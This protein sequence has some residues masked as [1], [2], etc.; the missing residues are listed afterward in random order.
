MF[1]RAINWTGQ[2]IG[3]RYSV[4]SIL[5]KGGMGV[6][7]LAR[8]RKLDL[9]VVLKAP[10]PWMLEDAE[11]QGRFQREI[12]A[13]AAL[14]HPNVVRILD[15]GEHEGIPFAVMPHLA[16]GSLQDRFPH[17]P[18]P[19]EVSGQLRHMAEWLPHVAHALDFIHGEGWTHRDVK[20][21][22]ILFDEHGHVYLGDFGIAKAIAAHASHFAART[23]TGHALGTVDY[24]AP[25]VVSAKSY[26]GRADQYALAVTIFELL[27]GR[28]PFNSK[29]PHDVL[30]QKVTAP[31]P[32]LS[33]LVDGLPA[34]FA[35]AIDRSLATEPERRFATCREFAEALGVA[36]LPSSPQNSLPVNIECVS[37]THD[38][39]S[40]VEPGRSG[41]AA[42]LRRASAIAIASVVAAV[43]LGA[44]L[45][46]QRQTAKD[47]RSQL[48]EIDAALTLAEQN[49]DAA[50]GQSTTS[51]E[52]I[53]VVEQELQAAREAQTAAEHRAETVENNGG[54]AERRI[55]EAESRAD[56]AE[57]RAADA[58]S[59]AEQAREEAATNQRKVDH[60]A[61][62][63]DSFTSYVRIKS[64]YDGQIAMRIRFRGL[65]EEW[66]DDGWYGPD[67]D[68]DG[69]N[70]E[71]EAL[72]ARATWSFS[73][74][75]AIDCQVEWDKDPS[76]D[77]WQT[78]RK[79][80]DLLFADDLSK[81]EIYRLGMLPVYHFA[82]AI[83]GTVQLYNGAE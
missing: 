57:S 69:D 30:V 32:P 48:S 44:A 14:P 19:S 38:A 40:D 62:S 15:A 78:E 46:S 49:L 7:F 67:V 82:K 73:R 72:P 34:S 12:C 74:D 20:P 41:A 64:D 55:E 39:G 3:G 5:G 51:A 81:E 27:A 24:L 66:D 13:M 35:L 58:T 6:V 47:L 31:A 8:D 53:R 77:G 10:H 61:E 45:F 29:G 63:M 4:S 43:A 9:N 50:T 70:E 2:A 33:S 54:D 42:R 16:G 36:Q 68:E 11:F 80:V 18:T 21:T 76:T 17:G 25:E 26:D 60:M 1:E 71:G 52:R 79:H 59:E 75:G 56:A 28:R 83:D 37:P 22:N 23:A 65:D